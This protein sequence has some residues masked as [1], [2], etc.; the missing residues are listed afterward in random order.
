[1]RRRYLVG[2]DVSEPGRLRRVYRTLRGFG[3]PLQYSLFRCDLND[4]E[5]MRMKEALVEVIHHADD[6]VV[7]VDLGPVEGRAAEVFEC[8]GRQDPVPPRGDAVIV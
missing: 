5:R 7:I 2:Y 1:M 6:R 4:A 3:D 8:L